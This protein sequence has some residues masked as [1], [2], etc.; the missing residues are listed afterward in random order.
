MAIKGF[1]GGERA[2]GQ[3]G[4]A[5]TGDSRTFLLWKKQGA[6][7]DFAPPMVGDEPTGLWEFSP[8]LGVR[9]ESVT[10]C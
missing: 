5:N 4:F 9:E 2:S 1:S 6:V 10:E 7:R 3:A 8:H